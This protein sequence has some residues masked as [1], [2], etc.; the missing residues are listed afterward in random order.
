M[1]EKGSSVNQKVYREEAEGKVSRNKR[2]LRMKQQIQLYR[3]LIIFILLYF[4]N[5]ALCSYRCFHKCIVCCLNMLF[6]LFRLFTFPLNV[7]HSAKF[8]GMFLINGWWFK[9][10]VVTQ[11]GVKLLLC[12]HC[13]F[14]RYLLKIHF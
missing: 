6:S 5:R 7:S 12:L 13:R 10:Y 4:V 11:R 8:K 1:L 14:F 9:L 3:V 2:Q